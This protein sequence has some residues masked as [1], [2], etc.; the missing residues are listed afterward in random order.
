MEE[1]LGVRRLLIHDHWKIP[2]T[3][4]HELVD[5]AH[6]PTE[7]EQAQILALSPKLKEMIQRHSL[8]YHTGPLVGRD[9]LMVG[10]VFDEAVYG[11][12][13]WGYGGADEAMSRSAYG[14]YLEQRLLKLAPEL[15]LVHVRARPD[16][17]VERMQRDPH[18][19]GLLQQQDVEHVLE[20]FSEEVK[21]SL[22]MKRIVLDTSDVGVQDTL[23]QFVDG[24][25]PY[26]TSDDRLR[27]LMHSME[28]AAGHVGEAH[29]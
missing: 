21:K 25:D 16:V 1:T 17:I 6:L 5:E 14:R 11:P 27:I 10:Y 7:E 13:Y 22:I 26:L 20:R 24:M 23:A 9:R 2:H 29:I 15:V 3:S 18:S 8:V 12:L 19:N 28:G 4:G